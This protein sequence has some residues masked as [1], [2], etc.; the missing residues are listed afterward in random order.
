MTC[1]KRLIV[2][3]V[4]SAL[5]AS[6]VYC[7][8]ITLH[9]TTS[10]N[11]PPSRS[12]CKIKPEDRQVVKYLSDS[13][14]HVFEISIYNESTDPLRTD[15]SE[16][17]KP[18]KWYRTASEHGKTL[19]TLSFNYDV[20][21]LN[22]LT[23][24]V[25][26]IH[27]KLKDNPQGCFGSLTPEER[28][29]MLRA[30]VFDNFR[31]PRKAQSDR[32]GQAE[33]G[34]E[35][36]EEEST[37]MFVCNEIIR[38]KKGYAEFANRCCRRDENGEI[39]C[40]QKEDN[41]YITVLYVCI[42]LVKAFLFMFCPLLIPTQMYT[43]AYLA[44]EYVVN[45][46][47][48][49]KLKVFVSESATT[50]VRY[51]N[52]LT[53]DQISDWKRLR[54]SLENIPLDEICHVKVPEVRIKVQ[55]KRIISAN[56]PPTG[57][58]RSLYDNLVRCK[59]RG[60]E[61]FKECCD[62]SVYGSFEPLI[63]HKCTWDQVVIQF[64]K[65]VTLIL[66]PLPFYIRVFVYYKFE[67]EE[68][69]SRKDM[70]ENL[71]LKQSFNPFRM[72]IIQYLSPTHP[73][74]Y[75]T[76]AF[77][78]TSGIVIGFSGKWIR[79]KLKSVTKSAFHD[80]QNV[81]RTNVLQIVVGILI[82][83][84]KKLGLLALVAC[85]VF[86]IVTLP[87]WCIIFLLYGIPT[88]YLGYRLVFHSVKQLGG[89]VGISI[90]ESDK[91]MGNI[92]QK[93]YKV[94]KKIAKIDKGVHINRSKITTEDK[95]SP[96]LSG[97]GR[98]YAI[99]RLCLQVLLSLFCL[100]VLLSSVLMFVEAIGIIVEVLVFTMMGIIVNAGSTLRYV[101]MALLVIVYM[102]NCYNSVYENYL[103]FN[104]TVLNDIMDRV[105]DLKKIASLPSSMQENA[106]FQVRK[107]LMHKSQ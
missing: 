78:I 57:L 71:D 50:S 92:K 36:E 22:I 79:E 51:K 66:T 67:L 30:K 98:V 105:E 61:P 83:P 40:S 80:M 8:N 93:A 28:V 34:A 45:L 46:T 70:L 17:Y 90:F 68:L 20:L 18:W 102:H 25:E 21:S 76:Y 49:L 62:M 55:G 53:L 43:A 23:I 99:R 95:H 94:K 4:L 47:R 104:G 27:L 64:M 86:T 100:V 87:F 38:E 24:G 88:F 9:T 1:C 89:D 75:T 54:E 42:G 81:S 29:E 106:A 77:Y 39:K 97:F 58:L 96:C 73:L 13:I 26:R 33:N 59:I 41:L 37:V 19:L 72:N 6:P 5:F 11:G 31:R 85:P 56:E 10:T 16:T 15:V 52:R 32:Q 74:F 84:F 101:S 63:K 65:F 35:L 91:P 60:L 7:G 107:G 44:S 82:W 103:E 12:S 3:L 14:V 69:Q 2:T 48:E